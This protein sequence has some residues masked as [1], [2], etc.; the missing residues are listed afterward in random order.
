M[1]EATLSAPSEGTDGVPSQAPI[2]EHFTDLSEDRFEAGE[3]APGTHV[4]RYVVE[5]LVGRGAMGVVYAARDPDLARKVA[6]KVLR[7]DALSETA[8]QRMRARLLR[9]ARAM[10][11]LSHPEVITVYDVGSFGDQ[12]FV[13]MEYV[14][15]DTLR[16]WRT[17]RHRRYEEI[18][19]VYE[20]AGSGLAAAHEAGLVHRDFKPDNV[21]VTDDGRVRVTDFGLARGAAR[22]APVAERVSG[23]VDRSEEQGLTLTRTG[24]LLGT[25][26]YMA[27][28]QLRGA[29]ADARSDVFSFCVA[30][31]EALYG[32]RPFAGSTVL[33]LQSAIDQ[34]A[35]RAA[36]VMTRVPRWMRGVLLRGLRARAEERYA[37]MRELLDALRAAHG[38]S[39]RRMGRAVAV[40]A[41]LLGI[42][43]VVVGSTRQARGIAHHQSPAAAAA[44][45]V[46]TMA[47]TPS[48]DLTIPSAQLAP[49]ATAVIG[50][51]VAPASAAAAAAPAVRRL[52][53]SA[54]RKQIATP[55]A[56]SSAPALGKNGAFIL[57]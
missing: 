16:H 15:G 42:G 19:S 31:Y 50:P 13:A 3:L 52:P 27:P 36:P 56:S 55:V 51:E 24:S 29:I 2:D 53:A 34:G 40:G 35:V 41:T 10:A 18:L 46:T 48:G 47:A 8:R 49:A 37:S 23:E 22:A 5:G 28:E 26:A 12:L 7:A 30:F 17:A 33:A 11:R 4:G 57:E 43:A 9:E 45:Q 32:E 6:V 38:A 54:R 21:L 1:R 44:S 20:R 25:P 39:R 14:E